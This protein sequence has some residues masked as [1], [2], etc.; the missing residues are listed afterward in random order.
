MGWFSFR[1]DGICTRERVCGP[2]FELLA[3]SGGG[4]SGTGGARDPLLPE[5]VLMLSMSTLRYGSGSNGS[6]ISLSSARLGL[7]GL[8][9]LEGVNVTC[10]RGR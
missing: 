7:C 6:I 4:V 8:A 10:G 2:E 5:R 1:G 9:G 3:G